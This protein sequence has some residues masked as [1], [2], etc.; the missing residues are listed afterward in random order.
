MNGEIDGVLSTLSTSEVVSRLDA[1][2]IANARMNTVEQFIG[3]PQLAGRQAWRHVDSA[4]GEIPA[5]IPPVRLEATEPIM[6][7][8]PAVGEHSE[9][10]LAEIGFDAATIRRWKEERVI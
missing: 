5:L 3:H 9:A 10:I 8:I 4:A 6:G 7:A 1:A 2:Q